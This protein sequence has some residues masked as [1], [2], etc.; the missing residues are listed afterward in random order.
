MGAKREAAWRRAWRD[1]DDFRGSFW[2]WVWEVIGLG[3]CVAVS[4]LLLL[5]DKPSGTE[6]LLYPLV[7]A[8]VGA[9]AAYALIYLFNLA[10]APIRQRNEAWADLG[11]QASNAD[12]R[13]CY[14]D[15]IAILTSHAETGAAIIK[16][17]NAAFQESPIDPKRFEA[18]RAAYPKWVARYKR[19]FGNTARRI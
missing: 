9:L 19:P 15:A 1:T 10:L 6:S 17:I 5:P 3:L 11:A 2:F 8:A 7:G 12:K 18:A 13:K 16:E 14:E 4:A